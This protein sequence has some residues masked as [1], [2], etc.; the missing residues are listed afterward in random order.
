M[1][2][3]EKLAA[4][5]KNFFG[6]RPVTI[7]C[8]GDSVTHGCFEIFINA[9]GNIDTV[10]VHL[11]FQAVQGSVRL[12]DQAAGTGSKAGNSPLGDPLRE[13]VGVKIDQH[14]KVISFVYWYYSTPP[15][16][17]KMERVFFTEIHVFLSG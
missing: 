3:M 5:N 4:R 17:C 6:N 9:N 2:I 15:A 7:A 13:S 14:K 16:T 8:L 1:K 11:L 12:G 10:L